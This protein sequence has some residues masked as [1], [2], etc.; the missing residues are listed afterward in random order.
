VEVYY[1]GNGEMFFRGLAPFCRRLR[2]A[3]G[4][5]LLFNYHCGTMKFDV[6]IFDGT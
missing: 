4:W 3:L 5:F 2:F 1:D 6:E